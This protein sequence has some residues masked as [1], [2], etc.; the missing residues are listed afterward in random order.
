MPPSPSKTDRGGTGYFH[1]FFLKV[2]NSLGLW[3]YY[4]V[5]RKNRQGLFNLKLKIRDNYSKE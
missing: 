5:F 3:M 4:H 1:G 2:E